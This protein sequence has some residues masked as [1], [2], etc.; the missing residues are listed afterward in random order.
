MTYPRYGKPAASGLRRVANCPGSH[1]REMLEPDKGS[2]DGDHGDRIHAAK[3]GTFP[4][5]MLT[6][7]EAQTYDMCSWQEAEL[8]L[9]WSEFEATARESHQ[10]HREVRLGL[11]TY[12]TVI[13][14]TPECKASLVFTGQFDALFTQDSRGLLLDYKSLYGDVPDA[15]DNEQIMGLAVLSSVHYSL[16]SLRSA[17]VQPRVGPPTVADFDEEALKLASVWL[18]GVLEKE[19]AATV[20]DVTAGDW[21]KY[22]KAKASCP[23]FIAARDAELEVFVPGN[24]AHMKS[25]NIYGAMMEVAGRLSDAELIGRFKGLAIASIYPNVI[26]DEMR[27]RAAEVPDFPYEERATREQG[28]REITDAQKAFE[29]LQ[30]AGFKV[31]EA[32]MI[33]ASTVSVTK[34]QEAVRV[35]SGQKS[36]SASGAVRYNLTDKQAKEALAAALGDV[37]THKEPP[38]E[39]VPVTQTK[40]I[41]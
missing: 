10:I 20:D 8:I 28:N 29:R 15:V 27:R 1:K 31:N 2:E 37:L 33:A 9:K 35:R 21:C 16:T 30:A 14:V 13:E 6:A 11:T 40:N 7:Q 22:C 23:A 41:E 38:L 5:G 12:G 36:V 17:I 25:A 4:V 3:A 24:I 39:I 19:R 26:K 34:L 18:T 32:D